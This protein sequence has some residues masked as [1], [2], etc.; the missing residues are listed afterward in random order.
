MS[1]TPALMLHAR[2][3]TLASCQYFRIGNGYVWKVSI[4]S[5]STK[6]AGLALLL[7][8]MNGTLWTPA[9]P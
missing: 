9:A 7:S 3:Y 5:F 2:F 6:V 4:S 1:V 8:Y